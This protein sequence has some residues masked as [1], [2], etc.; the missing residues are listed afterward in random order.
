MLKPI[1]RTMQK[2]AIIGSGIGGLA[3]AVRLAAQGFKVEV[4]E[5]N[6]QP[7]GKIAQISKEGFRFDTGPSLFTLPELVEELF[8]L[9]NKNISDYLDYERIEL[10]CRYF[11]TNGKQL[12][13]FADPKAFARE[14][15]YKIG[16]PAKQTQSYLNRYRDLYNLAAPV[17]LFN[18]FHKLK[19]FTKPEFRNT[20][21]N[22]HKLDSW[23]TMAKRN[24]KSFTSLEARQLFNRYATYNG[25]NPYQSPATL[26]MISH[27]EHNLG[28]F[29]PKKG[30]YQIVEAIYKLAL[31]LG[32]TFHFN[33]RITRLIHKNK[34]AQGIES[35]KGFHQADIVISN[36]DAATFYRNVLTDVHMPQSVKRPK[37]S[38]SAIIFYWGMNRTYPSLDLHNI[39]FSKDYKEEFNSIFKKR[40]P[41]HDPTTYLFISAKKVKQ[42]APEGKENW[43]VMINAPAN[44]GQNWDDLIKR[45]K[46]NII[47][48]IE[49]EIQLPVKNHIEIEHTATP[50]SIEQKTLSYKGALYGNNSNSMLSAF[51]RHAN[52]SRKIKN[53][54]F[55]GGSVH[56]G[57]GIPLCLCSAKIVDD[58]IT[59]K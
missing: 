46:E 20:L 44:Y 57:G 48:K 3:T 7:G 6:S 50:L 24:Q 2:A 30:M 15:E 45:A 39:L 31:D 28:A 59:E 56:P 10:I 51:N 42:D 38:S 4:F 27:L 49:T 32:I 18:S 53:L 17:F 16:E 26:N 55:T 5:K 12:N 58:L 47:K 8:T 41:Y 34:K 1:Y 29:F 11:Y 33:T 36:S 23:L 54:Y 35:T 43:F 25:S 19:N 40:V 21:F 37:L 14:L 9:S 22:I 13:A 52:F